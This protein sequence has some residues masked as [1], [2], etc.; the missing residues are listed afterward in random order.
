MIRSRIEDPWRE[1]SWDEAIAYAANEFRRIQAKYGRDSVG[2]ISSSRC[3]NEEVFLV[4]K[5]VRGVRQQQYRHLRPCLPLADRLRVVEDLRHLGRHSGFQVRRKVGR[6]GRDSRQSPP[7]PIRSLLLAS[8]SVSGQA[9]NS[10]SSIRAASIWSG[11]RTSRPTI[12]F[13]LKPGTNV[14]VLN[15]IAH[16]VVTEGLVNETFVRER[17][18]LADFEFLGA[19]LS[20]IPAIRPRRRP[21]PPASIPTNCAQLRVSMRLAAMP[22]SITA[23]ASLNTARARRQ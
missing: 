14:A 16:V 23:L 1:V 22:R 2:A 4:Q 11:A 15:A 17:C 10:S 7:T 9:R 13:P 12:T 3:T 19:I 6:R 21:R 20:P 5:M 8:R 18:D